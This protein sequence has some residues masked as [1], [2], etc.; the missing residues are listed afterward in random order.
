ML[1]AVVN[2]MISSNVDR[3]HAESDTC[4]ELHGEVPRSRLHDVAIVYVKP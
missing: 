4:G 2:V 1:H 3:L